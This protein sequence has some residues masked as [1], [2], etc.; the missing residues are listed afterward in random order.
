VK[1][2]LQSWAVTL[3]R[4][5][6]GALATERP[7]GPARRTRARWRRRWWS[8]PSSG[9][10]LT[11]WRCW[12]ARCRCGRGAQPPAWP[13]VDL[14]QPAARPLSRTPLR[15]PSCSGGPL[16]GPSPLGRAR[17]QGG[18]F[19]SARPKPAKKAGGGMFGGFFR[20]GGNSAANT[21]G[22]ESS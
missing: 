4:Q 18:D 13:G 6:K 7:L 14:A 1:A 8:W 16:S 19:W 3:V 9:T 22:S 17:V 11:T 10:A 21:S 5:R 2:T 20:S 12:Y 15:Q